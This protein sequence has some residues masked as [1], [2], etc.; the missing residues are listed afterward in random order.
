M[1]KSIVRS[2]ECELNDPSPH[3]RFGVNS[4]L[5]VL[6]LGSLWCVFLP[7]WIFIYTDSFVDKIAPAGIFAAGISLFYAFGAVCSY[8]GRPVLSH[9]AAKYISWATLLATFCVSWYLSWAIHRWSHLLE[10]DLWPRSFPYPD[11]L[12]GR[13]YEWWDARNPVPLGFGRLGGWANAVKGE[14]FLFLFGTVAACAWL[15]GFA[16]PLLGSQ[17]WHLAL[18]GLGRLCCKKHGH[19]G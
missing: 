10:D 1:L 8:L 16:M 5:I 13:Y 14:L 11:E 2:E 15:T 7:H 17:M 19:S 12:L 18:N 6:F 4:V 9:R 3:S